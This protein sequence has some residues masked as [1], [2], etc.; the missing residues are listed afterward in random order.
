MRALNFANGLGRC[1]AAS[2][3]VLSLSAPALLADDPSEAGRRE[4]VPSEDDFGL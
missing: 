2:L 3:M 4:G 1:L